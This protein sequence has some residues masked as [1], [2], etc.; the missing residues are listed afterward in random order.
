MSAIDEEFMEI[1]RCPVTR[2]RLQRV[3]D[4]LIAEVGGLKY[5]IRDGIPVLLPEEAELPE[6]IASLE[7]FRRKFNN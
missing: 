1:V 6:G 5:P 2:S 4:H 3:G 7:E